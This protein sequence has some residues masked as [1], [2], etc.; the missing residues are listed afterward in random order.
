M[1]EIPV[2]ASLDFVGDAITDKL[3]LGDIIPGL[4]LT[5]VL[6][7]AHPTV[8]LANMIS[9]N[10][11][12]RLKYNAW[13]I[14]PLLESD[15]HDSELAWIVAFTSNALYV[16]SV[17]HGSATIILL[18]GYHVTKDTKSPAVASVTPVVV[19]GKSDVTGGFQSELAVQKDAKGFVSMLYTSGLTPVYNGNQV[20][21]TFGPVDKQQQIAF[22]V[23]LKRKAKFRGLLSKGDMKS[24]SIAFNAGGSSNP[25]SPSDNRIL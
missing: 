3:A 15:L 1:A 16:S 23:S 6:I 2:H 11:D 12:L 13:L 8:P 14:N 22:V 9:A 4:M 5:S 10:D 19:G 24:Q 25:S 7:F 18:S 21:F 20:T 17:A